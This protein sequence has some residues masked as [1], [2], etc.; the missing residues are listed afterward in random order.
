MDPL[1]H[2]LTGVAL[3]RAG[4]NRWLPQG[5]VVVALAAAAPDLDVLAS[6]W[7]ST[8]YLHYHRHLTHG[9]AAMPVMALLPVLL[10][11][12]ASRRAFHWKRAYLLSLAGVASHILI[13]WSNSYGVRPWLPFSDRW[14][15][16]DVF[17]LYDLWLWAVLAVAALA[18]LLARLVSSE[19]GARPGSG[20]GLAIFALVFFAGLGFWRFLMHERAL[21]VLDSRLH[22]GVKPQRLAAFPSRGNPWRWRGLVETPAF[23]ALYELDLRQE[24]DPAEG[25][26]FYK[27]EPGPAEARAWEA[28]R[29]TLDFEV[30]LQFARY[31]FRRFRPLPEPE[32]GL[33]VEVMDLRFS[34]PPAEAFA[35]RAE[36]GSDGRVRRSGFAFRPRRPG[37]RVR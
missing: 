15:S 8:A 32:E 31:P 19:I 22:Q 7:G 30:F 14:Y 35:A 18:P 16:L 11:G 2:T 9:L 36:V 37:G 4:L 20:R 33:S 28:A 24:F 29:H 27:P 17:S 1:T 13:D 5:T 6:L 23:Y 34:D 25:R 10:V 12:L 21:A 3:G 26:A